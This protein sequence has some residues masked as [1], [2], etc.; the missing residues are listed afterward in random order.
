MKIII[1]ESEYYTVQLKKDVY[2][3]LNIVAP[4]GTEIRFEAYE[5]VP[6]AD[7][8]YGDDLKN[9]TDGNNPLLDHTW[10]VSQNVEPVDPV[11]ESTDP[12]TEDNTVSDDD[13]TPT[14]QPEVETTE[15]EET[16]S[17][18]EQPTTEE[19]LPETPTEEPTPV[20]D[21]PTDTGA[22]E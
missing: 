10:L 8:L 16:P 2:I 13:T 12:I 9:D 19:P 7:T 22:T 15:T 20:G 21:E 4:I 5:G 14:E 11:G 3:R 1:G 18:S 17:V 6:V